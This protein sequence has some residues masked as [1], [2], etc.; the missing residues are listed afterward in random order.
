MTLNSNYWL[1]LSLS[2][3]YNLK[4]GP[5]ISYHFALQNI[6][7]MRAW[8]MLAGDL[9][10]VRIR[11]CESLNWLFSS[12]QCCFAPIDTVLT[13]VRDREPRTATSNFTQLVNSKTI[14]NRMTASVLKQDPNTKR[15]KRTLINFD[16]DTQ[17]ANFRGNPLCQAAKRHL[18]DK[19]L[20]T[21]KN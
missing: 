19:R 15:F 2:I 12:V 4:Y 7:I 21:M 9:C 11:V 10:G 13:S 1:T 14:W 20:K 18:T 17:Y 5:A 16:T 6:I 8:K 3:F